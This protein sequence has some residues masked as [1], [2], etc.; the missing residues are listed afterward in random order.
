MPSRRGAVSVQHPARQDMYP[1]PDHILSPQHLHPT[2][3]L[4]PA[5]HHRSSSSSSSVAHIEHSARRSWATSCSPI[6]ST[7]TISPRGAIRTMSTSWPCQGWSGDCTVAVS[8][9]F[10]VRSPNLLL[11][12]EVFHA[13]ARETP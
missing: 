9:A 10:T 4:P 13:T 2:P 12:Q 11:L 3:R 1:E 6:R 5:Q 7:R 8:P